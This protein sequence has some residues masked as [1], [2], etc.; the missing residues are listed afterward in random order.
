MTRALLITNPAAARTAPRAVTAIRETLERGGWSVEVLT[1]AQPG[2]AR[3]F[4][5]E[6][7]EAGV[8][9]LVA[10]GGDGTLMEIAAAAV[11]GDIPL[12]VIPGG[13][14]NLLAGNLRLP[15]DPAA[16]ARVILRARS[17]PIDLGM[18]ERADGVHYFAVCCGTGFD[19]RLMAATGAAEKRRWKMA[20][21][22][23]RALAALPRVTSPLHR[24]TVDGVSHDLPAAMVLVANCGE[25][26]PPFLRLGDDIAPDDGRLD[27]LALRATGTLESVAA[28]LE[29]VRRPGSRARRLWFARGHRIAVDVLEGPPRPMQL[30]GEPWGDTPFE[31]SLV[32]AALRVIVDPSTAP[33]KGRFGAGAVA[34]EAGRA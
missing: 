10:F 31:A 6:G 12:G 18:V 2:D 20:A 15:R 5:H 26:I 8:D 16:A 3:R 30:D 23:V 1:T 34:G 24:V 7:R 21:Y 32:P 9:V 11:G 29:L 4:A 13:T 19:A 28:F 22:V 14:G 33:L 17:A 25:L 27:V